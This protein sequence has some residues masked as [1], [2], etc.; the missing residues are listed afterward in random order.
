MKAKVYLMML[1]TVVATAT[2]A[3]TFQWVGNGTDNYWGTDA[4]WSKISGD[5]ERTKPDNADFAAFCMAVEFSFGKTEKPLDGVGVTYSLQSRDSL[6][7]S[8][9]DDANAS[10]TCVGISSAK[11]YTRLVATIAATR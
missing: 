9:T 10:G 11:L 3:D 8:W 2:M 5:S 6:S 7:D 4:N 1:A